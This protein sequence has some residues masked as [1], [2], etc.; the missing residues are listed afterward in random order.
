MKR[1]APSEA[2]GST[3]ASVPQASGPRPPATEVSPP[4]AAALALSPGPVLR[5]QKLHLMLAQFGAR[6]AGTAF[7]MATTLPMRM[8]PQDL[9]ELS[10]MQQAVVDR[11]RKQHHSWIEGLG[12]LMQERT[13]RRQ[14][15]TLSKYVES[16]YNLV[17]QF[18]A[19]L[20]DQAA[21]M[22]GLMETIQVDLGYWIAQKQQA[23]ME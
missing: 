15:N 4:H 19:L 13:E 5:A 16:E 7:A 17:A 8:D 22:A 23:R 3:R 20:A 1:N 9:A 2:P 12:V 11:L 18:G 6:G 10:A 21:Q 14:A